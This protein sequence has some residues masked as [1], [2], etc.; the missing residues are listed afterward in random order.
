[1]APAA[2]TP[3]PASTT[4][5]SSSATP[6]STATPARLKLPGG[7]I[8]LYESPSDPLSLTRYVVGDTD[9]AR[10]SLTGGFDTHPGTLDAVVSPDGRYLA[11]R[12]EDY[13]S[14]GYDSILITDRRD[15]SSFRVKTVHKPMVSGIRNFSR[16]GSRLLLDISRPVGSGDDKKWDTV[17]FV[18]VD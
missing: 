2:T 7:D 16:D 4:P 11:T 6:A 14:D 10:R 9:Y 17:G 15:G 12:P 8:Y 1:A 13:T 3:A 18:I 5:S